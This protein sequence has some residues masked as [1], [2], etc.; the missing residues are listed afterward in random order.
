MNTQ[1]FKSE[2]GDPNYEF[3]G[4][5][6]AVKKEYET[7]SG[8]R[9]IGAATSS[10][11][12]DASTTKQEIL[13]APV[14]NAFTFGFTDQSKTV[15]DV[16]AVTTGSVFL[17][18]AVIEFEIWSHRFVVLNVASVI[19]VMYKDWGA[20][21]KRP[22][23]QWFDHE[24]I[25][26]INTM[27]E[28]DQKL[29]EC[30]QTRLKE[31]YGTGGLSNEVEKS[32]KHVFKEENATDFDGMRT[33]KSDTTSFFYPENCVAG[34]VEL[35][36]DKLVQGMGDFVDHV[37]GTC[38]GK[39][40]PAA[41]YFNTANGDAKKFVCSG[42]TKIDAKKK[43]W[44]AAVETKN[45]AKDILKFTGEQLVKIGFRQPY[46][47]FG[48][49]VAHLGTKAERKIVSPTEIYKIIASIAKKG[50]VIVGSEISVKRIIP[51]DTHA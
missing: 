48:D 38:A 21:K 50:K 1:I 37:A 35:I 32:L 4:T 47:G 27:K 15:V 23:Y 29:Y 5:L 51:K 20:G 14:K 46:G 10:R 49:A 18:H 44:V 42:K 3:D 12:G 41:A 19:D 36:R 9:V 40:A 33:L 16:D 24:L 26:G 30:Q 39:T 34:D 31:L 7:K 22:F 6:V 45:T 2:S 11:M 28:L 13:G 25:D 43:A 8:F 17:D